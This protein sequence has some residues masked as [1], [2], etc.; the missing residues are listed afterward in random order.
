MLERSNARNLGMHRI[1]ESGHAQDPGEVACLLSEHHRK[2]CIIYMSL[3]ID[4]MLYCCDWVSTF[5][6]LP[7]CGG[8]QQQQYSN[9]RICCCCAFLQLEKASSGINLAAGLRLL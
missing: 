1:L 2:I 7:A 3:C 8:I 5:I 6:M 9:S 4:L